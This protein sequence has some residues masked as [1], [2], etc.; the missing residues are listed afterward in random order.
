MKIAV[1]AIFAL[2]AVFGRSEAAELSGKLIDE[3]AHFKTL[4]GNLIGESADR[5]FAVY[6]PPSYNQGRKHYPVLYLLHGFSDTYK[7]WVEDPRAGNLPSIMDKLI[8]SGGMREM[9][10]VMVDGGNKLG[11][12]FYT[13]SVTTGNWEDYV[14]YELVRYVDAKYRTVARS[15]SRGIAGHSMGGYGAIK[16]AMK[17]PDVFGAVYALSACCL[18][19]DSAW[20]PESPAWQKVLATRSL[21][22][23]LALRTSAAAGERKDPQWFMGFVAVALVAQSAAFSADPA[24]PPVFADYPVER[25]GDKVV[26]SE[27][28]LAAWTA[29]LPIPMLGQYRTNLARLRGIGFEIGKQDWNPPLIAQAHDLD[30]MLTSIGIPHE[31][32][33]FTGSH[34]DKLGERLETKALPFFS[35]VL[36]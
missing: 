28:A 36:E 12:S 14:T 6:V 1:F 24:S 33:E 27:K 10:V 22:D 9:I 7:L 23:V 34:M 20:L 31:F 32:E 21:E 18:E 8:H 35:R 11:G 2:F 3:T 26:A 15:S 4:E 17:H 30:A 19:G 5:Q 29:N 25:R 13:N 16:L